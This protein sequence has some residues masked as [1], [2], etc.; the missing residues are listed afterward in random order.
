MSNTP[1][2]TQVAIIGA[3]PSGLLLSQLLHVHGID[4]VVIERQSSDYVAGR[5]RAGVLEQGTV[6]LL[7][8]AG[9]GA[10][11]LRERLVHDG[12]ALGFAGRTLHV[13]LNGLTGYSVSVY[14]Q[15]EVTKDLMDARRSAQGKMVYEASQVSVDG[16]GGARPVVRYVQG[17]KAHELSCDFIAGCDGY[18]GVCRQSVAG[19]EL[20]TFERVYPFGWL[21]ILAD[22]P[23]AMHE[24]VYSN[25]AR[26]FALCSMRSMT[27]SRY[28]VQ[29]GL[30]EKLENWSDA[31]FWDELRAR[32]PA[33]VAAAV[34]T[35]PSI[36]K[37]IA[38]LRS[39]VVE[40]LRFGRLFLVGDAAH[41]VPPTGAK[42]LNLAAADVR[43][44]YRALTEHY[45]TGSSE[46][47]ER[48]SEQCLRRI[49]KA[50]RFSWW[51]TSLMHKFSDDEFDQR[52][53]LAELDYLSG[54]KAALTSLAENYIGLPFE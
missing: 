43:V 13:D 12:F 8:E 19:G 1:A 3:G 20:R 4:N 17:G 41:I 50:E 49:W 45:R 15:T 36:E 21:G 53:Q 40:P 33:E 7:I 30:D 6:D 14:G 5:I 44:L 48:Y 27:R 34:V 39:F 47:I 46:L 11:M 32:L 51:F 16:F 24:L 22:V 38:P 9:V 26:G 37:S 35:G 25:H 54:S 2:N 10:R 29:C 31:R 42:G 18:H 23:P 52:I 28:Y